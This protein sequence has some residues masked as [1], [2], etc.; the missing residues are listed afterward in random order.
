MNCV[1]AKV[2]KQ[3]TNPFFKL[4]SDTKLFDDLDLKLEGCVP[5]APDHNLDEDSWFKIEKFSEQGFFLSMLANEFDSKDFNE[6]EKKLFPNIAYICSV[7]EGDFYFQKITPSLFLKRKMLVFG[8]AVEVEDSEERLVLN[9]MPDA[10][11]FKSA[12]TLV[13][14]SLATVSSIFPGIDE[15]YREA[16][17]LEVE[18]FLASDFICLAGDFAAEKVSKPNRKRIALAIATL[19]GLP[20]EYRPGMLAYIDDYCGDKVKYDKNT[21]TFEISDDDSLKLLVYGIEQRFYTTQFG[22]EKRL[23]NSVQALR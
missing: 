4:I 16:T 22:Q 12:D 6:F 20:P 15:L 5:Y 17:N 23:A 10:I 1:L 18:K 2:K 14:R 8:D 11:Y 7:Q 19:N 13:F 3:R 9:D 21:E